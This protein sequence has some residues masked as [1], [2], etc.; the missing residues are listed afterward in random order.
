MTSKP[1]CEGRFI[2]GGIQEGDGESLRTIRFNP[3][4][5]IKYSIW[6]KIDK[7][8]GK[9]NYP[10]ESSIMGF[11]EFDFGMDAKIALDVKYNCLINGYQGLTPESPL[12]YKLRDSILFDLFHTF[13]HIPQDPNYSFYNW[14]LMGH[15]S[16]RTILDG[17]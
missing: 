13:Y 7:E 2:F 11:V 12:E 4:L 8:T 5:E 16:D 6:D 15:L 1:I 10:E 14:A 3:P 9:E 17:E